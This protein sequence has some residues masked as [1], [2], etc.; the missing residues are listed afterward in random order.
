MMLES[1]TWSLLQFAVPLVPILILMFSFIFYALRAEMVTKEPFDDLHSSMMKVFVMM[2]GELDYGDVLDTTNFYTL[3]VLSTIFV[4]F[5]ILMTV[6]V[7]NLMVGLSVDD[8]QQH[9]ENAVLMAISL[10][11]EIL[12]RYQYSSLYRLFGVKKSSER[13]GRFLLDRSSEKTKGLLKYP[14]QS[15]SD[16]IGSEDR[17]MNKLI[18]DKFDGLSTKLQQI[19]ENYEQ[20]C[21]DTKEIKE[22]IEKNRRFRFN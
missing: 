7:M 20:V 6:A 18:L 1:V 2:I 10:K 5:V 12:L 21:Q 13:R 16:P 11:V 9:R 14:F 8:I 17:S 4:L 22:E 19:Q 3:R 15:N